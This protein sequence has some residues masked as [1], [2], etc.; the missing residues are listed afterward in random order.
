MKNIDT[1]FLLSPK[2]KWKTFKLLQD[3]IVKQSGP[4]PMEADKILWQMVR[5]KQ[6]YCW[7]CKEMP[8]DMGIG[9]KLPKYKKLEII[10]SPTK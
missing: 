1:L 9:I 4:V 7:F 2:I 3:K 5:D 6:I 10:S 8:N